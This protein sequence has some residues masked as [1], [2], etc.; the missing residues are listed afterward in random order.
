MS[1][2]FARSWGLPLG[3][4]TTSSNE[5]ETRYSVQ[6]LLRVQTNRLPPLFQTGLRC[7]LHA[8]QS[9]GN[10]DP[11]PE[12]ASTK[13]N[14]ITLI[15]FSVQGVHVLTIIPADLPTSGGAQV[16]FA[17]CVNHHLKVNGS[18][19]RQIVASESEGSR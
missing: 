14:P 19:N 4:G 3:V 7:L 2:T 10:L 17:I 8:L 6:T 11:N 18:S 9:R 1:S 16:R 5:L 13:M 15:T 12:V